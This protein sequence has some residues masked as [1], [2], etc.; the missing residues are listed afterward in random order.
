MERGTKRGS[1][2]NAVRVRLLL[3]S[4]SGSKLAATEIQTW[5]CCLIVEDDPLLAMTH[6]DWLED[7]GYGVCGPLGSVGETLAWLERNSPRIAIVDF[8]LKH[9]RA[10]EVARE[11]KQ[12]NIPF[13]VYSGL[14]PESSPSPEF[15][16]VPWIEKGQGPAVLFEAISKQLT[17]LPSAQG[18]NSAHEV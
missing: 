7:A 15:Q 10:Y 5:P 12:R 1:R 4:A 16:N 3:G 6:E 11:L 18:R 8:G 2:S 14:P 9:G 13:V 17:S